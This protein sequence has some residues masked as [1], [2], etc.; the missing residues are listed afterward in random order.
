MTDTPTIIQK[1]SAEVLGTFVLVFFGVGAAIIVP[2]ATRARLSAEEEEFYASFFQTDVLRIAMAFGL[3]LMVGIYAFGRVSGA[4]FNPAVSLGAAISGRMPWREV[5]PYAGA[6]VVGAVL[7]SLALFV[8][9]QGFDGFEAE[10]AMGANTFG[11]DG[12]GYAWWAAL[13]LEIV[14]TAA[15]VWVILAVT[16][17]RNDHPALAPLAIGFTL[18]LAHLVGIVATGTSVNPARSIGPALFS[19]VD[20]LQQLWLFLIAPLLGGALAGLTYPLVLGRDRELT[21]GTGLQFSG[22]FAR[23]RRKAYPGGWDQQ[24]GYPPQGYPPQGYPPQGY[25]PQ[26]YPP[27]GQPPQGYPPPGYG[28]QGAPRGG[29]PQPSWDQQQWGGQGQQWNQPDQY[30]QQ[31]TPPATPGQGPPLQG[32]P[33]QA[34]PPGQPGPPGQPQPGQQGEWQQPP[35]AEQQWDGPTEPDD[36]RT[37]IR[38]PEDRPGPP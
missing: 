32:Q 16:D 37:H 11:D 38:P 10:G 7:A 33:G 30:Q 1:L 35:P 18:V 28:E 4:H 29:A 21:H 9:M 13:L 6:Q 19:G 27:Q 20:A 8:L 3:A 34:P 5:G 25:P 36:S 23:G 2:A 12:S 14:M 31:W 26:G 24:G 17:N 22:G 15:L